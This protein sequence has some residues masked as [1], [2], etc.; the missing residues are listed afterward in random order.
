M[1]K[2]PEGFSVLLKTLSDPRDHVRYMAV[3]GLGI[4]GDPRALPEVTRM[5]DDENPF[6]QRIA[7]KV[8]AELSERSK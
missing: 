2:Q 1:T 4:F 5:Q 6:V 8:A 3:K 7:G